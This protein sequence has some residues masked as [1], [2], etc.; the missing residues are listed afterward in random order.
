MFDSPRGRAE[1]D[2][3]WLGGDGGL[4]IFTGLAWPGRPLWVSFT[5]STLRSQGNFS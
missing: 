3:R 5:G 2:A 4:V 1:E